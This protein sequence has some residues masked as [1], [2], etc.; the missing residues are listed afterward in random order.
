MPDAQ[1]FAG[2]VVLVTGAASGI[3][4]ATAQRFAVEGASL[5]LAD[6]DLPGAEAVRAALPSPDRHRAVRHD[7]T[8]EPDWLATIAAIQEFYGRLDVL[9]NNAGAGR[10]GTL[11]QTDLTQWRALVAVN[12]DSVFMG[13]KFATDL[14][15]ASGKGAVVNVSSIRSYRVAP[16]T[17]PYSASKAGVMML[18]KVAAL[19]FAEAGLNIRVNSVH[20][21]YV[22]TALAAGVPQDRID[23]LA[24]TVPLGRMAEPDEIAAAIAFLAS[25]DASYMS[26]SELVVDGAITAT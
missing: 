11:A 6:I 17:G 18:T 5:I 26:G 4:A 12:L 7:V 10:H 23:A 9:V 21:G 14:L 1:R 20:P 2:R 25:D 24:A 13:I 3:G 19:E 16:G 15:A 8:S 22:K